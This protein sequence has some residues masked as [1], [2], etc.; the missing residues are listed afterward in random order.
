[1]LVDASGDYVISVLDAVQ[2][3]DKLNGGDGNI[4]PPGRK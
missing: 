2:V 3:I 1:M 4:S